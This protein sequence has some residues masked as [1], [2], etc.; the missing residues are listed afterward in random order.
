MYAGDKAAQVGYKFGVGQAEGLPS[1]QEHI[2]MSRLKVTPTSC[3]SRTKTAFYT[4]SFGGI[5]DFLG[6]GVADAGIVFG[7]RYDLQ[8]KCRTPGAIAPGCSLKLCAPL[9][10]AQLCRLRLFGRHAA[11]NP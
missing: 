4:V 2:V 7:Y 6:D 5:A 8:P 11:N 1:R 9:Q 3:R 10:A